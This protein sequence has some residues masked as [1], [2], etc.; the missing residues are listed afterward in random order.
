RT[1][2]G[3]LVHAEGTTRPG[4]LDLHADVVIAATGFRA[5]LRD[6]PE[7]GLAT[8][9]HGR[10]PAL[11]PFWESISLPGIYFAG[12][13]SDGAAPLNKRGTQSLSTSVVGFRYNARLL[14]RR[15]AGRSEPRPLE[16]DAVVPLLAR[17]WRAEPELWAQ[18]GY[19]ARVVTLEDEPRDLGVEPLAHFVDESGP[20][21]VAVTVETEPDGTIVPVVYLRRAGTVREE[22]LEPDVLHAFDGER[23]RRELAALTG[24][25][26][27]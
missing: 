5:P 3:F 10:I 25:N 11:T 24:L 15:L 23:Y 26:S 8:V 4:T 7:I 27:G 9:G 14:A 19:L 22:R 13:A 17:A 16:R 2:D 18:R 21:A 1:P 12:N 6:L 20:A